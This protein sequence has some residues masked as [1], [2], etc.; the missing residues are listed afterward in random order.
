MGNVLL[1]AE[2]LA[3]STHST[4]FLEINNRILSLYISLMQRIICKLL[5]HFCVSL[6]L[7]YILILIQTGT[8]NS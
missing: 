7:K 4:V 6:E 8:I 3:E 5:T 1:H 2:I